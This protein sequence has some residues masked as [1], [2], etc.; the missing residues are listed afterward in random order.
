MLPPLCLLI[1]LPVVIY[2]NQAFNQREDFTRQYYNYPMFISAGFWFFTGAIIVYALYEVVVVIAPE[3]KPEL[4]QEL[5]GSTRMVA[6]RFMMLIIMAV[7]YGTLRHWVNNTRKKNYEE[8]QI[9]K[10]ARGGLYIAVWIDIAL[11]LYTDRM[12]AP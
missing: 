12:G 7:S 8:Q 6:Q 5:R 9:R 2:A 4:L 10:M 3:F 1:L 11:I